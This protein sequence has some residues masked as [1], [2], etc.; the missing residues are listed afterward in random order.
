[1]NI[2]TRLYNINW[3]VIKCPFS[4][5]TKILPIYQKSGFRWSFSTSLSWPTGF[6]LYQSSTSRKY[7]RLVTSTDRPL[8]THALALLEMRKQAGC[9]FL[10][11][12]GGDFS[13]AA[14]HQSVSAAYRRSL[15]IEVSV[16][17]PAGGNKHAWV[18]I[19]QKMENSRVC[20][21][22][23][24]LFPLQHESSRFGAS[25]SPVCVRTGIPH[26]QTVLLHRRESS[27]NVSGP[28]AA[29][30]GLLVFLMTMGCLSGLIRGRWALCLH[31]WWHW[32]WC[33]WQWALVWLVQRT[34]DWTLKLATLTQC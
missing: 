33:S 16:K 18:I 13:S 12:P 24:V 4:S 32:P 15:L 14:V 21:K 10:F 29:F 6:T 22:P 34:L 11:F 27:E 30:W 7:A 2:Y 23:N 17:T 1:M 26:R 3:L 5:P 8:C 28:V 9:V 25:L 20:P 31:G 19:S